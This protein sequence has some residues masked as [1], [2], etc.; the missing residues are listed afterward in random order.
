MAGGLNK[1]KKERECMSLSS[2]IT[3]EIREARR[4]A[5]KKYRSTPKG[6]AAMKR[7][8]AKYDALP[9]NKL[10]RKLARKRWEKG[11]EKGRECVRRHRRNRAIRYRAKY[12]FDI[13]H[14]AKRRE[15]A[16]KAYQRRFQW[17]KSYTSGLVCSR[18]GES[19]GSC[20]DFHH[21]DP[22]QKLFN[23]SAIGY[24]KSKNTVMAEIA[25]CAVLCANCHRKLHAGVISSPNAQEQ[26]DCQAV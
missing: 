25:K 16:K 1:P 8:K 13:F 24:K 2:A 18:C 3:P 17:F 20:L 21:I 7:V 11:T 10:R 9:E 14:L 19:D 15:Q 6:K 22:Y 4:I 26:C 5:M 23:V 12:R